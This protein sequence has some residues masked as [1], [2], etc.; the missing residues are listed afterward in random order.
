MAKY[1]IATIFEYLEVGYE[2][3]QDNIP[4]HITHVDSFQVELGPD[5]LAG[6]LAESLAEQS[7]FEI[8]AT[9]DDFYGPNKDILVTEIELS[10]KLSHLH[11]IIMKMLRDNKAVL[12]NP[13]FH[14]DNYSPHISAYDTRKVHP[15]DVLTIDSLV[16]ASKTSD[17]DNAIT[18][19]LAKIAL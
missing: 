13:Q 2:F 18:R 11:F 14:N 15:G 5:E 9:K 1:G 17:E 12:K 10:P 8:K 19:I 6:L 3:S 4:L 16:I 7:P